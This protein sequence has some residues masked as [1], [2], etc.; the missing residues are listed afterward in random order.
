VLRHLRSMFQ[1]FAV[2]GFTPF[3]ETWSSRHLYHDRR[4]RLIQGE[5]EF[6]GTVEDIDEHG[7]LIVRLAKGRRVFHSGEI[8]MRSLS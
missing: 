3:R 6:V 1:E 2:K 8:S 7:G 4:V 5:R